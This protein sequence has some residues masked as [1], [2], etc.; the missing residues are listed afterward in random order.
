[1]V[2]VF[3]FLTYFT[4][5]V[6]SSMFWVSCFNSQSHGKDHDS[7]FHGRD[8]SHASLLRTPNT[9]ASLWCE[10]SFPVQRSFPL[11]H[12]LML[13]ICKG[14]FLLRSPHQGPL[15]DHCLPNQNNTLY[16]VSM[17]TMS[18]ITATD[19]TDV[20]IFTLLNKYNSII[21]LAFYRWKARQRSH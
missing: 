3:L 11:H 16:L 4:C 2:F 13:H 17:W 10:C 8:S 7:S 18:G 12:L 6:F 1:M 21:T 15:Y 9:V 14:R 5:S 20:V 19:L